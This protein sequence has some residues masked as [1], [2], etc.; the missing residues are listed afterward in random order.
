MRHLL[1]GG[2]ALAFLA[3]GAD[4]LGGLVR[5]KAFASILWILVLPSL[6]LAD[7]RHVHVPMLVLDSR[8]LPSLV[9]V[10]VLVASPRHVPSL[11]ALTL[12]LPLP[13]TPA[14]ATIAL[15]V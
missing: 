11:V 1:H 3:Q 7:P 2:L 12:P 8:H 14:A 13:Q 15:L 5:S 6:L 10:A 4:L 9:A